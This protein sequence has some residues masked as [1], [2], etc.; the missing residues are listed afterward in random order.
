VFRLVNAASGAGHA[1]SQRSLAVKH[2]DQKALFDGEAYVK[3]WLACY[4]AV[5]TAPVQA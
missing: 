5:H 3:P 1:Q 4:K 2:V